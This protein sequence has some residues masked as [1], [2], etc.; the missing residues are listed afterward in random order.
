MLIEGP[1]NIFGV[2]DDLRLVGREGLLYGGAVRGGGRTVL[3]SR[4]ALGRHRGQHL[5]RLASRALAH[6]LGEIEGFFMARPRRLVA[7]AAA[8]HRIKEA[9][10]RPLELRADTAKLG[11]LLGELSLEPI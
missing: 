8:L 11:L 2:L 6:L 4:T 10:A 5:L 9:E 1:P 3:R 7:L